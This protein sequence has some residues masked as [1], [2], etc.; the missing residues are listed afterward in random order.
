MLGL[1]VAF[2]QAG[3]HPSGQLASWAWTVPW[4]DEDTLTIQTKR[5]LHSFLLL[6]GFRMEKKDFPRTQGR[7]YRTRDLVKSDN[8]GRLTYV[9]RLDTQV[10]LRGQR[11]ELEEVDYHIRNLVPALS[12]TVVLEV[13][14]IPSLQD[15]T[16]RSQ[17]L[18]VFLSPADACNSNEGLSLDE[19]VPLSAA[20]ATD[21]TRNLTQ[22]LPFYMIR[23]AFIVLL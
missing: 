9:G 22:I 14:E 12:Y 18:V 6:H 23:A 3:L 2:N 17:R 10:K 8:E 13:V 11:V 15:S 16:Q 20:I 4:P 5:P 21:L 7:F 1:S 19:P